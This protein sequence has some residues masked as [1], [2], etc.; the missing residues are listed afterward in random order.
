MM[1]LGSQTDKAIVI[2]FTEL[3][4]LKK[5]KNMINYLGLDNSVFSR[6]FVEGSKKQ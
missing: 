5:N 6:L 4:V 3:E 2:D 1:E